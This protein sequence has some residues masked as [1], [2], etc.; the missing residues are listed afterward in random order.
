MTFA[1]H[2]RLV[3]GVGGFMNYANLDPSAS[4]VRPDLIITALDAHMNVLESHNITALADILTPGGFNAGA[5]RGIQ[6]T[7]ADIALFQ[8]SGG[9]AN[10]LDD[11]TFTS[12]PHPVPEP[13]SLVLLATGLAG[14][15]VYRRRRR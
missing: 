10:A 8:V 9:L 1:F 11:L 12:H 15:G 13:G 3:S 2:D 6:R 7:R 5:F 4:Q 14:L